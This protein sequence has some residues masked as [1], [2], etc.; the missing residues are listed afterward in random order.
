MLFHYHLAERDEQNVH[1]H[2]LLTYVIAV[3]VVFAFLR[4]KTSINFLINNGLA[5]SLILQGTWFIQTGFTLFPLK[6]IPPLTAQ[7][8]HSKNM[9]ITICFAVHIMVVSVALLLLWMVIN[10]AMK[11]FANL[12]S[13]CLEESR[14]LMEEDAASIEM[15]DTKS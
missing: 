14:S 15:V 11:R 13:P 12:K 2:T 7:D 1:I 10:C 6:G 4:M 8:E 3:S 9:Y 5:F